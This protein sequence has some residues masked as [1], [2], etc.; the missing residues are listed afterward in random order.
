MTNGKMKTIL[1]RRAIEWDDFLEKIIEKIEE[2]GYEKKLWKPQVERLILRHIKAR[3]IAKDI[4][5]GFQGVE[6]VRED[7]EVWIKG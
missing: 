6:K 2:D 7:V 3:Q 5:K 1:T 4:I